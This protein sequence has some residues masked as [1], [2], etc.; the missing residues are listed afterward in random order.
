MAFTTPCWEKRR[1]LQAFRAGLWALL[2]GLMLAGPAIGQNAR[3]D[4]AEIVVDG[5]NYVINADI[6]LSLKPAVAD[7]IERGI[8]IHFIVE[9]AI[10]APRWY[11]FDAT[12][13]ARVLPYRLT[14]QPITR[15]YRL[16]IGKLHQN[17]DSLDEAVR[18]MARVRRWM[19]TPMEAL[20]P[21]QSYNV[22][23]R[24]RLDTSQLPPPFQ[25]STLG[26]DDWQIG[27]EWMR[28]T[29]LASPLGKQ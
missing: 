12:V 14:Y 7:A 19:I 3:V 13:I 10:E 17:F 1:S 23:L 2:V 9:T 27:S 29:F 16:A 5:S 6:S 8:P 18:T 28:W 11:W 26:S 22:S 25:V 4:Y 15:S 24:F 20:T 21:G